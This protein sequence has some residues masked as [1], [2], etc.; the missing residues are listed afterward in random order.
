M[1]DQIYMCMSVCGVCVC[2]RVENCWRRALPSHVRRLE[3]LSRELSRCMPAGAPV[4]LS[5][6]WDQGSARSLPR[7]ISLLQWGGHA[8]NASVHSSSYPPQL[9]TSNLL[10][11]SW[12]SFKTPYSHP[13]SSHSSSSRI[14]SPLRIFPPR[15]AQT[16]HHGAVRRSSWHLSQTIIA[17]LNSLWT[18]YHPQGR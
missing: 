15:R 7:L 11:T 16:S 13:L 5:S 4:V 2:E 6:L 12:V 1:S 10:S 9:P 17:F 14:A 8:R 3:F 18:W